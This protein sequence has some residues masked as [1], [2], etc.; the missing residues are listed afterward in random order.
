M[1]SMDRAGALTR[2]RRALHL[3]GL[4]PGKPQV[5]GGRHWAVLGQAGEGWTGALQV[6]CGTL[7]I[8]RRQL[9]PCQA[10]RAL[11]KC[12]PWGK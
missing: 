9:A 8:E 7:A 10:G 5:Q 11:L 2:A 1:G 6:G 4:T 3:P 12:S